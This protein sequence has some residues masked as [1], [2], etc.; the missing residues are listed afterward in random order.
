MERDTSRLSSDM[1]TSSNLFHDLRSTR[2]TQDSP[3]A[4]ELG[5]LSFSE[6]HA[7]YTGNT[8]WI[9][10]LE[11]IQ[12]LKDE[13]ASD[14]GADAAPSRESTLLGA[15]QTRGTSGPR[16]S[17]LTS[18]PVL[19][20]EDILEMIP[21]RK[22]VDRYISHFFN[23]FDF[24]SSVLHSDRFLAEYSNFWEDTSAAPV[25][26]VGLLYSIMT[27]SAF[28]RQQEAEDNSTYA[29]EMKGTLET[30]R[31]LTI[32][33][34]IASN[35]LRPSRHTIEALTLHFAVDQSTNIDMNVG[36]WMLIGVIIRIA[37][38]M[39]LH[40][41]PSHWVHI[42]PLEAEYRRR[43]WITLY[44]MDFFTSTQVGL[45]RIIKD[46]QCDVRPPANL[47][48][49]D[50]SFEL[51]VMP[52]ERPLTDP[53]PLSFM[54]QRSKI[55]E[56]AAEIYDA[57][58]AGP[59]SPTVVATLNAKLGKAIDS[60]P[61]QSKY[62]SLDTSIADSPV[63]ILQRM[64]LDILVH[65]A[66]YLLHRRSFMK[67][68]VGGDT[69]ESNQLCVNAALAIL[70]HQ[71]RLSDESQPGGI[72]FGIRWRVASS[73]SHEFLQATMMLC[74][75]L[76][77]FHQGYTDMLDSSALRWQR[78]IIEALGTAKGIWD[79]ISSRS[80]EAQRAAAAITSVL[81]QE[82]DMY[83]TPI[84]TTLGGEEGL[85]DPQ[86]HNILSQPSGIPQM[87]AETASQSFSSG[88]FTPDQGLQAGDSLFPGDLDVTAFDS[89][90]DDPTAEEAM[91]F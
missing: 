82:A 21:S 68:R 27:I 46:S 16:L 84:K 19:S 65:K 88:I 22:V 11:D 73:L 63:T 45:P 54:I 77:R 70:H 47:Y 37:L 55:I 53:T 71:R 20:K 90:W 23:A 48:S 51:T 5:N 26:W 42:R 17:L 33:C 81:K 35:Y 44:H 87:M 13:L 14:D 29:A 9:T 78:N 58:E 60:I 2:L 91:P 1:G 43:L 69:M 62:R 52:P 76:K 79:R 72:M 10:I 28:L 80:V 64:C 85:A 30:Y 41:D 25:A 36:N 15:S 24:A 61:Q 31:T 66:T 56:V 34:L 7:V 39:G 50:L 3:V 57:T 49:T 74:L 8:H 75:A 89:F 38:R 18:N 67:E 12:T 59:P 83:T 4:E 6:N 40:R 86:Q 32:H